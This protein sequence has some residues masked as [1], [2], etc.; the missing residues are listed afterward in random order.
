MPGAPDS[1]ELEASNLRLRDII[2]L[3]TL[4]ALWVGA[5]TLRVAESLAA[6]LAT[7]LRAQLVLVV[8][9]ERAGAGPVLVAQTDRYKSDH[10]LARDLG[11]VVAD[12]L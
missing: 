12:W 4:P 1:S 7:T 11:D 8:L 9:K 5:G 6:A 3:S 2:S 10:A